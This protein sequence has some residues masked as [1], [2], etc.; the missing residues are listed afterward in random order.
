MNEIIDA[1]STP[2]TERETCLTAT[3]LLKLMDSAGIHRAVVAPEDRE[4]AVNNTS[5]ND[6]ILRMAGQSSGRLIPACTANPWLGRSACQ[7]LR[8]SAA[9]GAR[10]LVLAPALQGFCFGDELPA[11]LLAA[12]AE[13][14]VPV[15]VHSGPHSF[16]SPTQ[17]LLAAAEH[18]GA[19][20]ILGH[21]GSTDYAADMPAVLASAPDNVWFEL[22]LVRPWAAAAYAKAGHRDRLIFGSSAPRN[23]PAFELR[24][25]DALLPVQDYPDIFGGNFA[26]LLAEVQ[27]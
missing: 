23:C 7:E 25:L 24:M 27:S 22:S 1:Y 18:P 19:R 10:M 13:L 11:E 6:R 3:E 4:I 21:C 8:R 20:F 14:R 26:A 15:Y 16:G 2:G 5:G 9:A 17:L 12:S